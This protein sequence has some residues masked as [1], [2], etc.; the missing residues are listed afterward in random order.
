MGFHHSSLMFDLKCLL[1]TVVKVGHDDTV[2]EGGTGT[3]SKIYRNYTE[4]KSREEI[5]GNIGF[6]KRVEV[7]KT[8]N[9]KRC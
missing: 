8:Q 4:G 9:E 3:M 2:V 1:G 6:G 7:D 5:I